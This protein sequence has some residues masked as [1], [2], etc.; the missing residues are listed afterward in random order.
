[1]AGKDEE[2]RNIT[3]GSR[4]EEDVLVVEKAAQLVQATA[5]AER[6]IRETVK[7]MRIL[8]GRST[9]VAYA[10]LTEKKTAQEVKVIEQQ[11]R[12]QEAERRL[13]AKRILGLAAHR[14]LITEERN[15]E[16]VV[17]GAFQN[18]ATD[19]TM[20]AGDVEEIK[21]E[22]LEEFG[23]VAGSGSEEWVKQTY[24][25][26][27]A[28]EIKRPGTFSRRTVQA[29]RSMNQPTAI[30][31][32]RAASI[33]IYAEV[34][35]EDG[36]IEV[37]RPRISGLSGELGN[38]ALYEHGLSYDNLCQLI[39]EG[40]LQ[41]DLN[42]WDDYRLFTPWGPLWQQVR[43]PFKHQGNWWRL[44]KTEESPEDSRMKISGVRMTQVGKELATITEKK[45]NSKYLEQL[46]TYFKEK[47]LKL[48]KVD[49]PGVRRMK[50]PRK[51]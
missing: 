48:T 36:P 49:E 11:I 3:E 42:S 17:A 30:S 21:V 35:T 8:L 23:Q 20:E 26:I 5:G 38:N 44:D 51:E 1:M 33:A 4:P 13:E 15:I 6:F 16:A 27:L 14:R 50:R 46:I 32:Q 7:S 25:R 37:A 40:L 2:R 34:M 41:T 12:K 19:T 10:W 43:V 39:E 29:V 45:Q 28:G 47:K 9:E 31:F 24:A 22:W 18:L